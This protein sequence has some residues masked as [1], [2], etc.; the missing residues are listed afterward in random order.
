MSKALRIGLGI[1]IASITVY[2]YNLLKC[3]FPFLLN[4][5]LCYS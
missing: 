1:F 2:Y 4:S 5:N 3:S